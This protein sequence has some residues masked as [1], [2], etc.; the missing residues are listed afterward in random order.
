VNEQSRSCGVEC[1]SACA[2]RNKKQIVR[3]RIEPLR[4]RKKKP[5]DN[6]AQLRSDSNFPHDPK[7]PGSSQEV[8]AGRGN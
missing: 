4:D 6:N 5:T 8:D 3:Q 2:G 7:F 1:Q